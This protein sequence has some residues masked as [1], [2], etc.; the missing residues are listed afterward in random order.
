MIRATTRGPFL[1]A[2]LAAAA[3]LFTAGAQAAASTAIDVTG[4]QVSVVAIAPGQTPGVSFAGP[5]GSLAQSLASVG[6]PPDTWL[7]TATGG[8]AFGQASS[9][10]GAGALA[11]SSAFLSG[12]VFGAGASVHTSAY[13][14]SGGPDAT[15]QGTFGLGDGVAAAAFTLAPGTRMTITATVCAT[16]STT[17]TSPF[18][19]ADSG[20]SLVLGDS[21][22]GGSQFVR[23]TFDAFALG[24]FGPSVD[25]ETT[26]LNLVYEN[27][28]NAAITGLFSGYVGSVAY[29]GNPVS[30]VP[31]P[32]GA[33]MLGVGLAALAWCRRTRHAHERA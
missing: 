20:L 23:F 25:V 31:E 29:S 33:A 32:G 11:G 6:M 14:S 30:P 13:A 8:A 7:A 2:W 18:E 22:G 4:L 10:T 9:A 27:D 28:T 16:A 5:G 19:Y 24:L 3:W 12:D 21:Q 15:G 17:G 26:T 1:P